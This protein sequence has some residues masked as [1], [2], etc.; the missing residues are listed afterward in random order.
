MLTE[1]SL[2]DYNNTKK[3]EYYDAAGFFVADEANKHKLD[4][5]ELIKKLKEETKEQ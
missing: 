3:A 5:P 2:S 1:K 4:K